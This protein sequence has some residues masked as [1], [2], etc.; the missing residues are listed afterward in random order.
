MKKS[1]K[2]NQT[3]YQQKTPSH[4]SMI[5]IGLIKPSPMTL[6]EIDPYQLIEN[7]GGPNIREDRTK[8]MIS[9]GESCVDCRT[10]IRYGF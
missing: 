1:E 7:K 9:E 2:T 4:P 10:C 3:P 5:E 6:E 8:C